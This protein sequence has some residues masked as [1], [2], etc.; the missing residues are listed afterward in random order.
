[1]INNSVSIIL[2]L[3]VSFAEAMYSTKEG[4]RFSEIRLKATEFET[5]FSVQIFATTLDASRPEKENEAT[6]GELCVLLYLQPGPVA[7]CVEVLLCI[8]FHCNSLHK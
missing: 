8:Y 4:V 7:L 1:M 3:K 6:I 5:P 2:A